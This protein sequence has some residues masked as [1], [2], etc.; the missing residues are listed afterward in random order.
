[1]PATLRLLPARLLLVL[2]AAV[3]AVAALT[4]ALPTVSRSPGGVQGAITHASGHYSQ[5]SVSWN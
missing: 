4:L 5:R 1:V 2:L 3:L